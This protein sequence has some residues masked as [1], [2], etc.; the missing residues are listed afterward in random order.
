MV[1]SKIIF[2]LLQD[3]GITNPDPDATSSKSKVFGCCR[4]EG[5]VEYDIIE[6]T[7]RMSPGSYKH[8]AQ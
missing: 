8:E 7:Q 5:F 2:Y 1:H 6:R 3:G 4:D